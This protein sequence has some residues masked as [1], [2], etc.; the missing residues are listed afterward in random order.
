MAI[1]ETANAAE[2][3]SPQNDEENNTQSFGD[4]FLDAVTAVGNAIRSSLVEANKCVRG[5]VYPAKQRCIKF[6][7]NLTNNFSIKGTR[8]IIS[9]S[10]ASRFGNDCD[11]TDAN[12]RNN[13]HTLTALQTMING[14]QR[15]GAIA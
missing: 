15:I 13:Q 2:A 3:T 11:L 4:M 5:C 10:T 7:D 14:E 12:L 1:E 9:A 8:S 6:Y